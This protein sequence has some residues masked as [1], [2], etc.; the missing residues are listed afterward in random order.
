MDNKKILTV[1]EEKHLKERA[2]LI[3]KSLTAMTDEQVITL[4]GIAEGIA[5]ANAIMS[6]K[7]A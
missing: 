2:E 7:S 1:A 4:A 3:A 5:L 6:G